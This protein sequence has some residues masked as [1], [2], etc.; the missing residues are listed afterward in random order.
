L[1]SQELDEYCKNIFVFML[2]TGKIRFNDLYKNLKTTGLKLTIPTLSAHLKHLQKEKLIRRMKE[3]KQNVAYEVNWAKLDYL[4]FHVDFKQALEESKT[5]KD[6]FDRL[7]V[8]DRAIFALHIMRLMETTKLKYELHACLEPKRHFEA[9]IA[10]LFVKNY[11]EPYRQWL[12]ESCLDSNDRAK[13]AL[14]V[15]EQE[16][17]K[18]KDSIYSK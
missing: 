18:L 5:R 7:S 1:T 11:L 14:S 8:E 6:D 15:V 16:E 17:K 9:T 13:E 2:G 10:Y 12:I 3:G 4:R